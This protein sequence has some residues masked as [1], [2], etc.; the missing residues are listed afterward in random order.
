MW[1]LILTPIFLPDEYPIAYLLND[2]AEGL[3]NLGHSIQVITFGNQESSVNLVDRHKASGSTFEVVRIPIVRKNSS[4]LLYKALSYFQFGR[5][6][7]KYRERYTPPDIIYTVVPSNENGLAAKRLAKYFGCPCIINVQD[8]HPD[9]IFSVGIIKNSLLKAILRAQEKYMY[10]GCAGIT[11]IGHSFKTNLEHKKISQPIR[12]IP[13]WVQVEDYFA[14]PDETIKFREC[15]KISN[16]KFVVLYSGTFGRIHGTEVILEAAK[17]SRDN[18]NILYLLVGRGI[19]FDAC[20]HEVK[21]HDLTNVLMRAPV[22]RNQLAAL[23]SVSDI[24]LVTLLPSLGYTSIPS[25]VLGYMAAARPVLAMADSD[26]DTARLILKADCGFVLPPGSPVE[27]SAFLANVAV[28]KE[29]LKSMGLKGR[30]FVCENLSK[31]VLIPSLD[32]FLRES[33]ENYNASKVQ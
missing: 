20:E 19:G 32:S 23:Q 1:I 2:V 27:L 5:L 33:C 4:G 15:L 24:S 17:L 28:N 9:A 13:N 18:S 8:I 21:K 3:S 22:P 29:K 10:A 6:A 16:D 11:V 31:S 12:V 25:K 7:Y 30:S 26:C 14:T